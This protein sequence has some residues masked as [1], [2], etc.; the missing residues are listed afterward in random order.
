MNN[1]YDISSKI[2]NSTPTVK[3]NDE[4]IFSVN[5]RRNTILTLQ[6]KVKKM[7]D[8]KEY[9]ETKYMEEAL[10]LLTSKETVKKINDLNLP[11]PEYKLVFE[12]VMAAA[13][14]VSVEEFKKDK[15][16]R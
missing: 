10:I 6:M 12:V 13:T 11:F 1:V 5:N 8:S 7:D 3:V 16:F 2:S 4:L 14:G 15:R 9:D